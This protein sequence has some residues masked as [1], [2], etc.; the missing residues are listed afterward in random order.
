VQLQARIGAA[1]QAG[2]DS[3]LV[4]GVE[5]EAARVRRRWRD[6]GRQLPQKREQRALGPRLAG[7][8]RS[9]KGLSCLP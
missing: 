5:E 7:P 9:D 8:C 6:A 2:Y 3:E 1:E 4:D